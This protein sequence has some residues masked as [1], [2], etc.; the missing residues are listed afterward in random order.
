M[1][2]EHKEDTSLPPRDAQENAP[3]APQT[4]EELLATVMTKADAMDP[5]EPDFDQKKFFDELWGA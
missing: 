5:V 4:V 3:T 2:E 1:K